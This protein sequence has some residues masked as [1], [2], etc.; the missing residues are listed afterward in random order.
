MKMLALRNEKE[1]KK[2]KQK[3]LLAALSAALHGKYESVCSTRSKKSQI[4][5]FTQNIAIEI[6]QPS[7]SF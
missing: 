1:K 4:L 5:N 7:K 2:K 6:L 3:Q